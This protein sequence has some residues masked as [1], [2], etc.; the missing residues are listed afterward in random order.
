[1]VKGSPVG[2]NANGRKPSALIIDDS[3]IARCQMADLLKAA[4]M[5]VFELPSAIGAT[6]VILR[7][8]I[9][10]VVLDLYMPGINGDKLAAVFRNNPRLRAIGIVLVTGADEAELAR[11]AAAV[12]ADAVVSKARLNELVPAVTRAHKRHLLREAKAG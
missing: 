4:G 10:V 3:E 12:E 11:L 9:S 2:E 8:A 5:T 7:R 1:M 6:T